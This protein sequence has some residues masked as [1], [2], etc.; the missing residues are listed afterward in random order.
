VKIELVFFISKDKMNMKLT[1]NTL[2][3]VATLIILGFI[4]V[5]SLQHDLI[6]KYK[7]IINAKDSTVTTTIKHDTI[8]KDTVITETNFV[9]KYIKVLK[10]DTVYKDGDTLELT[11]ESK[12]FDKTLTIDKDTADLE[13]YT[14]GIET[15][16]DS[17]KMALKTHTDVVTNTVTVTK[18]IE[19]PKTIWNR[20]HIQPQVT[21][22]YDLINKQWGITAGIGVGIEL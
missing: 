17:L 21:S 16:L 22:G 13:I 1:N 7:D 6:N 15:S 2:L 20:I 10:R 4:I 5:A 8:W 18:Y 9:P 19:K 14:S 11:R 3:V 12:R